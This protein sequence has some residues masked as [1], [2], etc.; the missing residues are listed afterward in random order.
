MCSIFVLEDVFW[1]LEF[2]DDAN[3]LDETFGVDSSNFTTTNPNWL[4]VVDAKDQFEEICRLKSDIDSE[5][6]GLHNYS[7]SKSIEEDEWYE[8][9]NFWSFK[10]VV[11]Q[12]LDDAQF[13]MSEVSMFQSETS[14]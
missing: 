3:F 1:R 7:P 5:D 6:E 13:R 8:S 11:V 2:F 10:S 9:N 14:Y 12:N 4:S